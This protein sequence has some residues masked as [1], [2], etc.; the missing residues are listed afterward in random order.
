MASVA[1]MVGLGGGARLKVAVLTS[2][3]PGRV[4]AASLALTVGPGD[5]IG[6]YV[7]LGKSWAQF[8]LDR[9]SASGVQ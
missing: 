2:R 8:D 7:V 9:A 4:T 6:T 5:W 3:G 1:W